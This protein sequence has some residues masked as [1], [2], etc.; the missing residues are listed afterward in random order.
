[1]VR[2]TQGFNHDAIVVLRD[3]NGYLLESKDIA[4]NTVATIVL[5]NY[6][7]GAYLIEVS[8]GVNAEIVTEKII[9]TRS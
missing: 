9:F 6:T 4:G 3:M 7:S 8:N 5:S 2:N 1:M